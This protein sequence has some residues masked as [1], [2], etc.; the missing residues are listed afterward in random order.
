MNWKITMPL[1]YVVISAVDLSH[2]S[3][4]YGA[5]IPNDMGRQIHEAT[6]VNNIYMLVGVK[7]VPIV[8]SSKSIFFTMIARKASN[9][10][11]AKAQK[12][13]HVL[14]ESSFAE[15]MATPATIG[16]SDK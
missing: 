7:F 5:S 15:D 1:L 11:D 10:L 3:F 16:I 14:K 8:S 6:N 9:T 4:Q 13:D 12:N 2:V